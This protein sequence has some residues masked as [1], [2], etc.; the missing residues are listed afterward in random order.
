MKSCRPS[1]PPNPPVLDPG[2]QG[3]GGGHNV[4]DLIDC[5]TGVGAKLLL[6][7]GISPDEVRRCLKEHCESD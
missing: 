6:R 7:N 4:C 2:R 1:A 3:G 5:L